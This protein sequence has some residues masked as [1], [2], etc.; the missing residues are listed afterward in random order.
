MAN[1]HNDRYDEIKS[2]I[3]KSRILLEQ[4]TQDNVAASVQ[5]R[6]NQDQEYETAVSDRESSNREPGDDIEDNETSSSS[7]QDKTQK[8]RISGGILALHG[9]NKNNLDIT[10]DEK[11]AFQETMDEFVDEVSD[12]VDF[13]TLNVYPNNV[14]WSGKVIDQD[15][16][17][18][19]T[20]GEDSG[21]Y[22]N[23]DMIK[24]DA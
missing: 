22:I 16:E 1:I 6:I 15:I 3:K 14:D 24:V 19:F 5:K 20:I 7:P 2:L 13:N 10:T 9:K 8:Y 12:L 11:T 23:G 4:D 18:T 21:I 17:F